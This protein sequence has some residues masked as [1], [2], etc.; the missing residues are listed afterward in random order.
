MDVFTTN[1]RLSDLILNS[2]WNLTPINQ[3]LPSEVKTAIYEIPISI[4]GFEGKLVWTNAKNGEYMMKLGYHSRKEENLV[5][6]D[7]I[8]CSSNNMLE[9]NMED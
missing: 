4:V 2:E 8:Y 6:A 1:G 7:I 3:Y 5:N 9:I